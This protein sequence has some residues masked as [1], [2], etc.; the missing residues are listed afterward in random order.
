MHHAAWFKSHGVRAGHVDG[1][2]DLWVHHLLVLYTWITHQAIRRHHLSRH[3]DAHVAI[4]FLGIAV[5]GATLGAWSS[6]IVV[7]I[8]LIRIIRYYGYSI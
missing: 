7:V 4:A 6:S 8:A 5:A 3:C 2:I 1:L